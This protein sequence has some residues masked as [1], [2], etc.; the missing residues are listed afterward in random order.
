MIRRPPRSTRGLTLFPYTTLF[1]SK[2]NHNNRFPN[3]L[4]KVVVPLFLA[5]IKK[6]TVE[7]EIEIK[8][9]DVVA[10][11]V[12]RVRLLLALITKLFVQIPVGQRI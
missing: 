12:V 1:R 10:V 3:Q 7:I 8:N 9:L 5:P 2:N 11:V 6:A 4:S